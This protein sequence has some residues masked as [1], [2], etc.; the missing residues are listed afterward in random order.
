MFV[1]PD[2]EQKGRTADEIRAYMMREWDDIEI[3]SDIPEFIA[4]S[5]DS[6]Y[7]YA[8]MEARKRQHEIRTRIG[9]TAEEIRAYMIKQGIG[10]EYIGD[11]PEFIAQSKDSSY[12]HAME[13]K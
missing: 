1:P 11:I 5:K 13:G 4:Q 12:S 6:S 10:V 8:D 2:R 9:R 7:L 3:I